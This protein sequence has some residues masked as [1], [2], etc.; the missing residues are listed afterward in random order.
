M[1]SPSV[2]LSSAQETKVVE[3]DKKRLFV[4]NGHLHKILS[5]L[6]GVTEE[7][8]L[9]KGILSQKHVVVLDPGLGYINDVA[10][11]EKSFFGRDLRVVLDDGTHLIPLIA[12]DSDFFEYRYKAL[13]PLSML[14]TMTSKDHQGFGQGLTLDMRSIALA[15]AEAIG[16][17]IKE[18]ASLIEGGNCHFVHR[19]DG[20]LLALVGSSARILTLATLEQTGFFEACKDEIEEKIKS[21]ADYPIDFIRLAKNRLYLSKLQELEEAYAIEENLEKK[22]ALAKEIV[23]TYSSKQDVLDT[24]PKPV[25][26][27]HAACFEDE[28]KRLFVM[29]SIVDEIIAKD[30]NLDKSQ[31]I[32]L[33]HE[34]YH[35]DYEVFTTDDGTVFLHDESLAIIELEKLLAE[36]EITAD[37]E[38]KA[39]LLGYL[40]GAN[41]RLALNQEKLK[42]NM[43]HL[44]ASGLEV[45]RVPGLYARDIFE[46][47]ADFMNG[48]TLFKKDKPTFVTF[49]SAFER[50]NQAFF[51]AIAPK[52]T[53]KP[54]FHKALMI[55]HEIALDLLVHTGAG[56]HCYTWES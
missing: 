40:E 43:A 29:F 46:V 10:E 32:F 48:I 37:E 16:A 41:E 54:H 14:S 50:L 25:L 55:S 28:A 6:V 38:A 11:E 36:K 22:A 39:I 13:M 27:E 9:A 15:D 35:L 34:K 4:G 51:Q 52:A 5:E 33:D 56:L 42:T 2:A 44:L 8:L 19:S 47:E 45:V 20:S 31:V 17:T 7:K 23:E 24:F 49:G 53:E 1:V 21:V 12:P 26:E 30:L 18:G 3:L